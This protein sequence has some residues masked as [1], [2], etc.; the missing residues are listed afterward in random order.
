[1]EID[2]QFIILAKNNIGFQEVNAYLSNYLHQDKDFPSEAPQLVDTVVIYPFEKIICRKEVVLRNNEYIGISLDDLRKLPF[3]KVRTLSNKLVIQQT[4]TFRNQ[5]D[6]NAHRLLR[7][8]DLNTLLSMLPTMEQ[9]SITHQMLPLSELKEAYSDF[10]GIW[11]TTKKI[12]EGCLV[13]F[14]FDDDNNNQN[15]AVYFTHKDEDFDYLQKECIRKLPTR[16]K[17]VT[18][19]I[20]LRLEKELDAIYTMN[21]VSYFLINY[22]IINY[23]K[24]K[25][26]PHMGRGSGANSLVA[27]ILGIT[28][29]DPIELDLYFERFINQF[30]S[31]P[32]DFDIDFG[33]YDREDITRYI[34]E[35]FP[36]TALMGTYVT[37][38][39][40][41]VVRELGKV[42]GLPKEEI[43]AFLLGQKFKSVSKKN[44]DYMKLI[45]KYGKLIQGFPNH[46]SV[47][48]GGILITEKPIAYF[49]ATF[50]PPKGYQTVQFDMNIAERVGIHKFDILSQTGLPKIKHTLEIIKENQ[51]EAQVKDIVDYKQFT[52]DPLINDL[53]KVGDC[54]GVFYVESPAMRVLMTKLGTQ[55]YLNLVAASS[56]IRPGVS[57]GG[58]KNEFILR[59]RDPERRQ[60]AHPVML[61]ILHDTYGVMVYQEDVLK[62]AHKFAGL[63][64]A[65]ADILRRGMRGKVSSKGQFE[66]IE[67]KFKDN[68]LAKGYQPEVTQEIWDQVKAFA[69]YAF[70]KGHSASYAV[71]SYQSLYLKKYFP[72]EF[73]TAVL[74]N[75]GGFYN[76]QTYINEIKKCGGVVEAPCINNSDHP[77][78]IKVK[79][80]Y[81]GFGMIKALEDRVIRRILSVR[82]TSGI[83]RS[84][85]DFI[86]RINI[87][88]E[89]LML[90]V[91]LDAFRFTGLD[92]HTV[93]WQA[94]FKS[95]TN[96][97]KPTTPST[98]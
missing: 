8:I 72:L 34:F 58:M 89:Q 11:E 75:G 7:T 98:I 53:L 91:R 85:D 92:K 27:Y 69:G 96:K 17:K 82:Q 47:H 45:V 86:D 43:D 21:F 25:G 19:E 3:S 48:A 77:N 36:N 62:V 46:L 2:Q 61:E 80:V 90:L 44:D 83:F 49:S 41:A 14:E 71:E 74:N 42:F 55:D 22:D 93:A 97:Q 9:G 67:Q 70:A 28:N 23:A 16:F 20:S 52:K 33:Y 95:K 87:S 10:T 15:Q 26:Y 63:S 73:M 51:P 32:P 12:L 79:T 13:N 56:I 84:F 81:L 88:V 37:F 18:D 50:M 54:I 60:Q 64:L 1:M 68:C 76:V 30:R 35:R 5:S 6:F 40:K 31:S 4:V 39:F 94:Q 29:V 38:Q 24:S 66:K 78:C 57:N 65:E 59:H